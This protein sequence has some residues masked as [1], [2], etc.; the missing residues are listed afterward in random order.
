MIAEDSDSM[1]KAAR[2][3]ILRHR[4]TR[5]ELVA[6]LPDGRRILVGYTRYG[7]R[8][9]LEMLRRHKEYW[10]PFLNETD[11]LTFH[12]GGRSLTLGPLVVSFSGV[13]EREAVT[14]GELPEKP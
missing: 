11:S 3:E 14:F 2:L 7:R 13:T 8:P 5:Y 10:L 6:L 9:M 12:A 1:T 4:P